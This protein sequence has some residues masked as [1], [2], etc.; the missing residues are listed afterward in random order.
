MLRVVFA[1][2]SRLVAALRILHGALSLEEQAVRVSESVEQ[3]QAGEL[4]L[5]GLFLAEFQQKP[6][7]ALLLRMQP[8]AV[9]FLWPPVVSWEAAKIVPLPS[10]KQTPVLAEEIEDALLHAA[11]KHLDNLDVRLAQSLLELNQSQEQAALSRNGIQRLT[12]LTFFEYRTTAHRRPK[13]NIGSGLNARL[14]HIV[15]RRSRNHRRFAELI[16]QTYCS[17]L[18]CPEV[19]G[20]RSASQSLNVYAESGPII[21]DLWRVYCQGRHDVGVILVI[22]RP[23]QK[24]WEVVYL[25]VVESARQKGVARLM[26][27]DVINSAHEALIERLMIVVDARNHPAISLYESLGFT[28]FDERVAFVRLGNKIS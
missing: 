6:V 26:V 5:S 28:P 9:A 16:E 18:D 25:G 15:Y 27:T 22:N 1:T 3:S 20:I 13:A 12:T 23:E 10:T 4:D 7:G 19:N 17:S 2:G 14:T 8:D 11:Q 24:A 21:P